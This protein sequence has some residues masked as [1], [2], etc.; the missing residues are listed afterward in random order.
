MPV[1]SNKFVPMLSNKL[2]NSKKNILVDNEKIFANE[3]IFSQILAIK[4]RIKG[5]P[6]FT[7]NHITKEDVI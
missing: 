6:V 3:Y 1:L 7:F 5:G 4:I 2:V